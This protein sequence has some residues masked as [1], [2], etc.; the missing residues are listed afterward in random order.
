MFH[1]GQP[2]SADS[3]PAIKNIYTTRNS[4]KCTVLYEV[5][6]QDGLSVKIQIS[7]TTDISKQ[8][9]ETIYVTLLMK[10]ISIIYDI[11]IHF[12]KRMKE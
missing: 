4:S 2:F 3:V 10:T 6:T 9:T 8:K 12:M 1:D 11:C 7:E 5:T